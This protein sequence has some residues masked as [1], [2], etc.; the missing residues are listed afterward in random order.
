MRF[1][2]LAIRLAIIGAIA[3]GGFIFRDR[4]MGGA[5]DLAVGD[6]F[7]EPASITELQ[8]VKEVQHHPCT[9]PHTSEVVFVGDVTG[10]DAYPSDAAFMAFVRASC[11]PAFNAY[12][13]LDFNALE[14]VDMGVLTPTAEGWAG[15]DHEVVCYA[16]RVDG[17]PVS[18]SFKAAS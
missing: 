15:G 9:E 8:E 18:Q 17:Q 16:V 13:G 4:L 1:A 5:G 2:G 11:I 10:T 6:C 3:L 7:D 12:T 14:A